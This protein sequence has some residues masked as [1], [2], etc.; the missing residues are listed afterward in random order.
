LLLASRKNEVKELLIRAGAKQ[1][2]Q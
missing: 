2:K 1:S